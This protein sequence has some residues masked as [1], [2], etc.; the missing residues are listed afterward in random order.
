MKRLRG[1]PARLGLLIGTLGGL[2]N[3]GGDFFLG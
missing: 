2:G 3:A 1:G